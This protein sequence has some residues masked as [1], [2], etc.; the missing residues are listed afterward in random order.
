MCERDLMLTL[1]RIGPWWASAM[2]ST[3]EQDEGQLTQRRSLL[4][5]PALPEVSWAGRHSIL[6]IVDTVCAYLDAQI[7]A[8][9]F[10]ATAATRGEGG[11]ASPCG[12]LPVSSLLLRPV[13]IFGRVVDLSEPVCRLHLA[14]KVV[15]SGLL[16]RVGGSH[17][18][19]V[20]A[21]F[22]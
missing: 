12:P 10:K 13:W 5:P 18:F 4:A 9:T 16:G 15:S 21:N 20:S 2:F 7:A 19:W 1:Q 22:P 3:V 6:C 11:R 8:L 14:S 17:D